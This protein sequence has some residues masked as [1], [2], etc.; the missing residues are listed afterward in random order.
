MADPKPGEMIL[1]NDILPTLLDNSYRMTVETDVS[2]A[3]SQPLPSKQFYFNVEG[4]RFTMPAS[5]VASVYPPRNGHGPFNDSL[6][7]VALLRR[8]LPW[9]R[10]LDPAGRIKPPKTP[11]PAPTEGEVPWMALLL[12]EDGE[13]NILPNTPLEQIVPSGVFKDLGSPANIVCDALEVPLEL[14]LSVLPA[15]EELQLLAHVRQ[16]NKDDR[17]L[18]VEGS[19]GFFAVVASSRLPSDQAKCRACLVSLEGRSDLV[20]AELPEVAGLPNFV[21]GLQNAGDAGSV[22]TTPLHPD[23]VPPPAP[24]HAAG[25]SSTKVLV[26][27]SPL[28]T[29]AT[30]G[31]VFNPITLLSARLVLL[32]S[33]QFQTTGSA[34]FENLMQ[35]LDVGMIGKLTDPGHPPLTDPGHPPLTDTF[36]LQMPLQDRAGVPEQTWYRGPLV[37]F[38]LTR[39]PLGP[40]HCADQ[41]RRVSPETGGEDISY[42][43]AF[44]AGRLL[45]AADPRLAQELM[46]W[47]R[48]AYS[49]SVVVD[50][51]AKVQS[52][53]AIP[54]VNPYE[55]ISPVVA[56]AA[57]EKVAQGAG[58][59]ADPS[60]LGPLQGVVGLNP[61]AVQAAYQLPSRAAAVSLLGGDA[62]AL[63]ASVHP[64][65][66]TVRAATTL[67]AVAADQAG[68]DRLNQHRDIIL[69][70]A[71]VLGGNL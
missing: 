52:D 3:G 60:G 1:Y 55:P 19:N 5:E 67:Q 10:D 47:R 70:N 20:T 66:Q 68:L 40:Y 58:P 56:A 33:W 18:S 51:I 48:E 59:I 39:D 31:M 28:P 14:L 29:E 30:P 22:L 63:G 9:E 64:P 2:V 13:Y 27:A 49:Q 37:P 62:G 26:K 42:A 11:D 69:A 36:H 34:T 54:N 6:P 65:Q 23:V 50:T 46:R 35:A 53:L 45:A 44:E 15:R 71:N 43:A 57:V 8:T 41:A 38:Q 25:A 17:E 16:V 21:V 24:V 4:P 61:D 32:H 12:F 7:H